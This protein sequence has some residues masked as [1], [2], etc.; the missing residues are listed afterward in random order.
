MWAN[1]PDSVSRGIHDDTA[2]ETLSPRSDRPA[3]WDVV[4]L[5]PDQAWL[6][7]LCPLKTP[8]HIFS[9]SFLMASATAG[10]PLALPNHSAQSRLLYQMGF[11]KSLCQR[12]NAAVGKQSSPP[13]HLWCRP[14]RTWHPHVPLCS[15]QRLISWPIESLGQ[16]VVWQRREPLS[17]VLQVGP[18]SKGWGTGL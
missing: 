3:G 12:V 7:G 15:W 11:R 17:W 2:A 18:G 16:K 14:E 8:G 5:I 1:F 13:P 6:L 9:S 10:H 4:S